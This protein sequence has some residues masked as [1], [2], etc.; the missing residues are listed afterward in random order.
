M[1]ALRGC[2]SD[3][4]PLLLSHLE[5]LLLSEQDVIDQ[6][7]KLQVDARGQHWNVM[8]QSTCSDTEA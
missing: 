4:V 1:Q 6:Q 5:P 2:I 7:M 3:Q 8:Q